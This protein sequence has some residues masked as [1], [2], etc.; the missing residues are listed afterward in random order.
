MLESVASRKVLSSLLLQESTDTM[1]DLRRVA[2]EVDLDKESKVSAESQK[3][4][5]NLQKEDFLGRVSMLL[6]F[7]FRISCC[8]LLSQ[9]QSLLKLNIRCLYLFNLNVH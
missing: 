5:L 6:L 4:L 1:E 7:S 9:H 2:K 3:S 8:Y